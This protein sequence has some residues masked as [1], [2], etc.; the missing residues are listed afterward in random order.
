MRVDIINGLRESW[1]ILLCWFAHKNVLKN[2]I[3][4]WTLS[5]YR[6]LEIMFECV[7]WIEMIFVIL[8]I[9]GLRCDEQFNFSFPQINV[10]IWNVNQIKYA[11]IRNGMDK[12]KTQYSLRLGFVIHVRTVSLFSFRDFSINFASP[13]NSKNSST[14]VNH[15]NQKWF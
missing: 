6:R 3:C 13:G 14:T 2:C 4:I 1:F 5:L 15:R 12:D 8:R 11:T 9:I 7:M 10:R